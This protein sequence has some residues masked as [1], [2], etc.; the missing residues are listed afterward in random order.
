MEEH[1]SKKHLLGIILFG[2]LIVLVQVIY[3]S[4]M[5]DDI[6]VMCD[7]GQGDGMY[8]KVG[9]YD[10]VVDAGRTKRINT[11]I[12][13]YMN[14][15][16]KTIEL[17]FITNS[18]IDHFGGFSSLLDHYRIKTLL[19]PKVADKDTLYFKLLKK[20]KKMG[21]TIEFISTGDDIQ[22]GSHAN[23]TVLWPKDNVINLDSNL[24]PMGNVQ[25]PDGLTVLCNKINQYSEVF[26]FQHNLGV[27]ILFTGDVTGEVLNNYIVDNLK[28]NVRTNDQVTILKVPHHGSRTGLTKNILAKSD[29][30]LAV[31]SAGRRNRYGHPH[32]EVINMLEKRSISYLVTA[33]E[34][35]IV[36]NLKTLQFKTNSQLRFTLGEDMKSNN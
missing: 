24:C 19:I 10:I 2:I 31:I 36:L 32:K 13:K 7:I 28:S 12:G 33:K 21:T 20:F 30:D 4:F 25:V 11:C 9:T 5:S 22:L 15:F 3:S 26:W 29:F 14:P 27:S 35:T 1:F 16:N 18:D 17:A 23:I 8:L 6:F 34:G